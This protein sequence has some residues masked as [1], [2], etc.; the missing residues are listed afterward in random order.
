[1]NRQL[2]TGCCQGKKRGFAQS[3]L[4]GTPELITGRA[5]PLLFLEK[6]MTVNIKG[7]EVRVDKNDCILANESGWCVLKSKN[8]ERIYFYRTRIKTQYLHRL[9][10]GAKKSQ[11]V[12]HVKGNTLDN[13]RSKLRIATQSQ[14]LKNS[15]KHRDNTSG[16]KGV[17]WHKQCRKWVAQICNNYK[18]IH[19]GLFDSPQEAHKAYKK[20]AIE[21]AKEF[22][23]W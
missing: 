3:H 22:A 19:L 16:Y 14:N 11:R 21:I 4:G 5:K 20:A 6:L 18:H 13:R 10:A 17:S 1:M 9:I 23:R 8:G 12:D 7:Y 2:I 15:K